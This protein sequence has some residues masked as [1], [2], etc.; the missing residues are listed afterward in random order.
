VCL[1]L[2]REGSARSFSKY[3][4]ILYQVN[5][6]ATKVE[7]RK[8]WNFVEDKSFLEKYFYLQNLDLIVESLFVKSC[9]VN[10]FEKLEIQV[11][12]GQLSYSPIKDFK[13]LLYLLFQSSFIHPLKNLFIVWLLKKSQETKHS[14]KANSCRVW[15]KIIY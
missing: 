14:F 15:T 1:L 7:Y 2:K 10:F 6:T 12:L 8:H 13:K 4:Q 9:W 5:F 11:A 3:F